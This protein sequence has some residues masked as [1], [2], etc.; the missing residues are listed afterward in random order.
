[1]RA[2]RGAGEQTANVP[3]CG[4][5]GGACAQG[6]RRVQPAAVA[7]G[8]RGV[9]LPFDCPSRSGPDRCAAASSPPLSP[10]PGDAAAAGAAWLSGSSRAMPS[11]CSG[12][13]PVP[14]ADADS[15]SHSRSTYR[16]ANEVPEMTARRR[17]GGCAHCALN[18]RPVGLVFPGGRCGGW[19]WPLR[20][21]CRRRSW[22]GDA[23][24]AS[25][26]A[27]RPRAPCHRPRRPP[28]SAA[29]RGAAAAPPGRT[30][31]R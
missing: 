14:A 12:P 19:Q 9:G 3:E 2:G 30:C 17:T 26:P 1:M 4:Q 13:A 8:G 31:P 25:L 23:I 15:N 20:R 28:R 10:R 21:S 6:R 22:V 24:R 11:A 5:A 18:R 16:I 29:C 7:D 27:S